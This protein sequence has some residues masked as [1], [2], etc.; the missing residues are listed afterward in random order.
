MK[1]YTIIGGVN[2]VGISRGSIQA[3]IGFLLAHLFSVEE[4]CVFRA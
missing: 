1:I 3:V 2:G 4:G